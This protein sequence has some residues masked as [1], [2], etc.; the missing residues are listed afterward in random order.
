[1]ITYSREFAQLEIGPR[2]E[3]A[4]TERLTNTV[5][6]DDGRTVAYAEWGDPT[7][8]PLF[9]LHGTPGC[10]LSRHPDPRLWSGL[11]LRVITL[12]RPG[13]G[14]STALPGRRVAHA[15]YDVGAV[16][17]A[18]GLERFMVIGGSGG[19]PHALAC[20]AGLGDRVTACA[21]VAS[22][23]PLTGEEVDGLIG[24]NQESYRVF[25]T[26]GR[27]GL[28]EFLGDLRR[29]ILAD[30]SGAMSGNLADAPRPDVEWYGRPEVQAVHRESLLEALRPGAQGWV[31][32]AVSIFH[33]EWGVDLA[34]VACP[35]R[36]WHGDDDRNGPLAAV[37]RL[38]S[39]IPDARVRVWHGEGHSAPARHMTD[40]LSELIEVAG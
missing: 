9:S 10:R 15:P 3:N 4:L 6:L 40:I 30:P 13:Y 12:D 38:A 26:R 27:E 2:P 14:G 22:A 36:F 35:V 34:G 11:G 23:A 21:A 16:A 28:A 32:D 31:D 8:R 29:A 17:D 24:L 1:M 33:D 37:E 39:T 25:S 5:T 19:G 18:L 7:G 20:A